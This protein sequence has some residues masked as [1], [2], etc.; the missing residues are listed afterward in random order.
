MVKHYLYG[1]EWSLKNDSFEYGG[2]LD[3]EGRANLR[4]IAFGTYTFTLSKDGYQTKTSTVEVSNEPINI[5]VSLQPVPEKPKIGKPSPKKVKKTTKKK[6]EDSESS[7]KTSKKT[8]KK[9][10]KKSTKKSAKKSSKEADE[11][12]KE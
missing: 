9:S 1:A 2:V 4:D 10:T 3:E 6:E 8:S 12:K 7:K 5:E 11:S